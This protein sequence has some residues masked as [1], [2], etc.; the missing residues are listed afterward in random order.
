[1]KTKEGKVL[2]ALLTLQVQYG[3][4][5]ISKR[6]VARELRRHKVT[7]A[8]AGELG[9]VEEL[10]GGFVK[11]NLDGLFSGRVKL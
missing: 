11:L 6:I 9:L 2:E 10:R 8:E 7:L 3:S 1:M 4:D 5:V